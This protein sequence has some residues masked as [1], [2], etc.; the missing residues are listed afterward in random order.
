LDIGTGTGIW[1]IDFAD[2]FPECTVTGTDLS[3]IQPTWI[4]P[5]CKFE[6]DDAESPWTFGEK[7][8]YIHGRNLVGAIQDWPKLFKQCYENLAPGGYL[9]FQ[10]SD[11]VG[12][13]SEDKSFS[14]THFEQYQ[15]K[16][17]EAS[18]KIDRRLDVAPKIAE[19]MRDAGFADVVETKIK[20][21]FGVWP[22]EK[23]YKELGLWGKAILEPGLEAYGLALMTRVLGMS[24]KEA[25]EVCDNAKK[26]L[27]DKKIH[28]LEYQYVVTARRPEC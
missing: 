22:K 13:F 20:W 11:I 19:L 6:V 5:K 28:M 24:D 10:E 4:P 27:G 3:A 7:F 15:E 17:K 21:P 9:E 12:V 2:Q 14:G 16:M 1:A 23:R 18:T 25:R 26:E 8:D